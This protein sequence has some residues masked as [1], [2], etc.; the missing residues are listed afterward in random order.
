[1]LTVWT[2]VENRFC[3]RFWT[4]HSFNFWTLACSQ[5]I[6]E[7]VQPSGVQ[8]LNTLGDF[9]LYFSYRYK[10]GRPPYTLSIHVIHDNNLN[11][12]L[13]DIFTI[14]FISSNY[15]LSYLETAKYL[16]SFKYLDMALFKNGNPEGNWP[17]CFVCFS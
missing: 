4:S 15:L 9:C 11:S 8:N 6:T 12:D 2:P 5:H 14:N 7:H 17:I 13:E 1:M 10:T 16:K 3:N